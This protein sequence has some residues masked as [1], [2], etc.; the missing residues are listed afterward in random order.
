LHGVSSADL[1]MCKCADGFVA[2][3]S[4]MVEDFLS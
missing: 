4:T 1:E 2:H 3:K